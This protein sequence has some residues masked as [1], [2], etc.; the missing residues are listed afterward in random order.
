MDRL[1]TVVVRFF[2]RSFA[3]T[4]TDNRRM[5]EGETIEERI[6]TRSYKDKAHA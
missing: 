3:S 5:Y 2:G 6:E 1:T 4:L